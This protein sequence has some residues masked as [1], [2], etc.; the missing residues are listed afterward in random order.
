MRSVVDSNFLQSPALQ[1]YLSSSSDH[2]AVL[3]DY[4]AM[5]AYKGD[6]LASIYHSMSILRQYPGQVIILRTTGD[7][8][9]L[10]SFGAGLPDALIDASQTREFPAY[11]RH[12]AAAERGNK[13]ME[14]QLLAHGRAATAHMERLMAD[15]A[16]MP[17]I[18][19]EASKVYTSAELKIIRR[20]EPFTPAI[21]DKFAT[22]VLQLSFVLFSEHPQVT[23]PPEADELLD[24]YIFRVALCGLLLSL[25]WASVGGAS[26]VKVERIRNDMVDIHFAAYATIFDGLLTN[27]QKLS[28][29]YREACAMLHLM[30]SAKE[31]AAVRPRK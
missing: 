21:M 5:E 22:S 23:H 14:K 29:I 15:A 30:I 16:L 18:F 26:K 12:L 2:Y 3:N 27:D 13:A 11:C 7:I 10:T 8:C 4:A 25:R 17:D 1:S 28:G 19:N 9:G 31:A 6:T 24:T 20:N